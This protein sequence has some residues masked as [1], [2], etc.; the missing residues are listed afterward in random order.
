M[1]TMKEVRAK[2]PQYND[3]S[4]QDLAAALHRKFY[5][6]MPFNEFSAKVGLATQ[7]VNSAGK[8]D[9]E[10][11]LGDTAADVGMGA[12]QGFQTGFQSL[13]GSVGDA[14]AITGDIAAWGAGRL[15]LSPEA[16]QTARG[17]GKRVP[18]L[19]LAI[20]AP[21]TPQ[22]NA[23]FESV[24]GPKYQPQT[25]AGQYARGIGEFAPAAI[26]GPGGV[27]R[28]TAMAVVPGVAVEAAGDLT[29]GNPYAKAAAGITAGVL[30]AGRGNAGTKQMLQDVGKTDRAYG[31]LERDVNRAYQRL[32]NA[33]IKYDA[34]A[35][36][37]AITDVTQLRVNP[38]LAPKAAGLQQ[39]FATFSGKGMD[40]Q[41][42]DEME[43]IATGILR[44]HM[45]EPTD[46]MFVTQI[47][48]KIKDVRQ[49]GA[50]V[51]NGSVPAGEVNSLIKEAK[52]FARRRII[53][54]DVN[55]M[56]DKSEW[57]VSGPESGL[58]NQFRNYGQKNMQNLTDAEEAAFRSVVARE[59]I[60][61]PLH[62]AGS[63]L[64]QIAMGGVGFGLGGLAGAIIPIVGSSLARRFMEAYTKRGVENALKT[65]LAGRSA[66][67]K[68]AVRDA[69]AKLEAQARAALAADTAIRG[70]LPVDGGAGSSA[71]VPR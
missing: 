51:T 56:K 33:G 65:V 9:R 41:D 69:V 57:Y 28:K 37:A 42:L 49:N 6:D 67:E 31:K 12:A 17:I 32:R 60:L 11:P 53:A 40:F 43:R 26:A 54:R 23:A 71:T 15:G 14:Q 7:T 16:Q 19:G 59:G 20:P 35:V 5:S 36:D 44:H 63:R 48:G 68:A 22:V 34:N 3:M 66:Q 39:Q 25:D 58:R 46:K 30:T 70:N 29:D 10:R 52:E 1:P 55:T 50:F 8:G 38:N 13:L 27:A 24:I 4:D 45:T 21:T 47:L 2:F 18:T 61:N 64:G 62:N